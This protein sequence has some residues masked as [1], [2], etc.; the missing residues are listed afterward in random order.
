MWIGR[1]LAMG[2]MVVGML[3]CFL[4]ASG[5]LTSVHA[6][7][8]MQNNGTFLTSPRSASFVLAGRNK[9]KGNND[10]N[11]VAGWITPASSYGA[12][13]KIGIWGS[14]VQRHSQE[15]GAAISISTVDQDEPFNMIEAGFHVLP[16]L[17]NNN[18]VHF[19]IRWTN[20]DHKATGCYN[21]ECHGFVPASGAALVP[22]QAVAP[23]STYGRDD[24]YITISLH[25]D[26]NTRDW[27]L[28][29]D[30]L[31]KP[32]FLGH[33]PKELCPRLYGIASGV[34]LLGFVNYQDRDKGGPAM[35][36]GH[37]P[38]E[39]QRKAAYFKNIKLFDSKANVYDPSGLVRLVTR[40][41][42]YKISEVL[43]AKKDGY[44]FYYGGPAG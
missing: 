20:D 43:H 2:Y 7:G 18:D 24:R 27:V 40:P 30:D 5:D 36:S 41:K 37:F 31:H 25:T 8:R 11:H 29:R 4:C 35:G 26:A 21:L 42:C 13:V 17:Y 23:P 14:Q 10:Y 9:Y 32:A 44:M 19:F 1:T 6:Y 39:G 28:Y 33:F 16:E 22:G 38:E 12:R 3:I 15:S 34:A